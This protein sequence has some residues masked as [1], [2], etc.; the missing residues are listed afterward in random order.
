[1]LQQKIQKM[2]HF[3]HFNDRNSGS[4]YD[5]KTNDSFFSHLLLKLYPWYIS[6]LHFK[7]YKIQS[8]RV[9]LLHYVLVCKTQTY[10]PKM[11]LSRLLTWM[12][13]FYVKFTNICYIKCFVTNLILIW[14][15]SHGLVCYFLNC[16]DFAYGLQ[17][18]SNG[19]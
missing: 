18:R 5:N 13:S 2:S 4:K 11:T 17:M 14:P 12:S 7:T 6:F 8:H 9:P 3:W 19:Q 15:Q 10:I 16:E 1:M